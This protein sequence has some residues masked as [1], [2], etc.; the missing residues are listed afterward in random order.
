MS[1]GLKEAMQVEVGILH[2]F[3]FC[4]FNSFCAVLFP[5][6]VLCASR[7]ILSIHMQAYP[8]A[9]V[10]SF[11]PT[12]TELFEGCMKLALKILEAMGYALKLQVW[13][14]TQ[15]VLVIW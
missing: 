6:A 9:L 15:I 7:T 11:K 2:Y 3:I 4:E 8:D 12:V 1:C 14:G 10:P 5:P 13:V